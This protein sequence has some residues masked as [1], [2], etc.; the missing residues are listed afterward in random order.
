MNEQVKAYLASYPEPVTALFAQLRQLIYESVPDAPEEK[1]WAKMPSYYVGER[2]VR[3]I[4]F[5]DHI[6]IEARAALSHQ[7]ELAGW[8]MTPKGMIQIPLNQGIPQDM[9]KRIFAESLAV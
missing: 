4:P 7:N 2:F 8:K 6:N 1:L 3:L 5:K 9:L